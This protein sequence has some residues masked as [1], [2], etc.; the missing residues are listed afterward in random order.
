MIGINMANGWRLALPALAVFE[1]AARHG[2]FSRA[3]RELGT[4]QP[5]VSH[6]VGWLEGQ[7]R[8]KLFRR[9][10]RG[11]GLT[12][13]GELLFAA[14][15][16]SRTAIERA[17]EE[18]RALGGRRVLKIAT[19]YGFAGE[20]LIPRL[21]DLA[22]VAPEVEVRIIASH[23]PVDPAAEAADV[24]ILLGDGAWPGR[25]A[26]LLFPETVSAVT[27]PSF[28]ARAPVHDLADLAERRLL[29]LEA[30]IRTPWLTW[31]GWFAA[32]GI[33]RRPRERDFVFNTYSLV[34]QAAIAGQ[35]IALGW[36]P[37]IDGAIVAG[38]L[39]RVL[40]TRVETRLGYYLVESPNRPAPPGLP[41]FR[42]WLFSVIQGNDEPNVVY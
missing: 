40:P 22:A 1:A 6:H 15:S 31:Q 32:H 25:A 17:Q 8:C 29:H 36:H 33:V 24:A 21:A 14:A 26:T 18:I 3:A 28:L 37:L 13:E 9:L 11:V 7:L 16:A 5:A 19:D 34:Q 10:H 39:C 12:S 4:T 38:R 41:R 27:G 30:P 2:N 20:W 42:A 35:G 23:S